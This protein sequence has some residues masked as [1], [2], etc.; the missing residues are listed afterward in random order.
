MDSV[1]DGAWSIL[2][3]V[4][5]NIFFIYVPLLPLSVYIHVSAAY[6]IMGRMHVSTSFHIVFISIWL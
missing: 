6:S 1:I 4:L 5:S 2:S 3:S